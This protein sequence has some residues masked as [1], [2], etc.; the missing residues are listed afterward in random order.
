MS[1]P[2][3]NLKLFV[4]GL[5]KV[6]NGSVVRV[7]SIGGQL[8][9]N[10]VAVIVLARPTVDHDSMCCSFEPFCINQKRGFNMDGQHTDCCKIYIEKEI[11]E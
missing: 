8:Y 1:N 3:T 10:E 5:Y 7:A 2:T 9:S 4:G 11:K 6:S